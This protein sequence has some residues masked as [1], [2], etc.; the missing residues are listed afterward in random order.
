MPERLTNLGG[1]VVLEV[2][3]GCLDNS[4][5]VYDFSFYSSIGGCPI[6]A[7]ILTQNNQPALLT[8]IKRAISFCSESLPEDHGCTW[9]QKQK[10]HCLFKL[11]T[12]CL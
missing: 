7:K 8:V 3:K 1:P 5:L 2:G 11:S 12:L 4:S 10:L 6:E 9:Y